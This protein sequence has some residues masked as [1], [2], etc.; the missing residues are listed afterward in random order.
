MGRSSS[1]P[2]LPQGEPAGEALLQD[3]SL[4]ELRHLQE[5][6]S[7]GIHI[8][9]VRRQLWDGWGLCARHTWWYA[10]VE[11][12]MRARPLSTT[13]LAEELLCR[14]AAQLRLPLVRPS[15]RVR[16]LRAVTACLT[17]SNTEVVDSDRWGG[18]ASPSTAEL[19]TAQRINARVRTDPLL[20]AGRPEWVRRACPCCIGGAGPL[21]RRHLLATGDRRAPRQLPCQ[22]A[23]IEQRLGLLVG[24]MA[25]QRRPV[26]ST[27]RVSWVEA[28]GWL[29]GWE[30]PRAV[31]KDRQVG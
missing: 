7:G 28:L 27:V 12:E 24:S 29:A 17:C 14:A 2:P 18:L 1:G 16:G 25:W 20:A 23:E 8:P 10:V 6:L 9:A 4:P 30:F 11:I 13:L 22:L 19:R 21:C 31:T 26:D 15:R 5:L 3:L